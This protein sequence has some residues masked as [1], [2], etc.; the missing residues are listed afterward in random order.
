MRITIKIKATIERKYENMIEESKNKDKN[1][2]TI[3]EIDIQ[4]EL[5]VNTYIN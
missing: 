5:N 1:K 2:M 3:K 4:I